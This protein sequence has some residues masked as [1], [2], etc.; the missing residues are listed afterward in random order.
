MHVV[1]AFQVVVLLQGD[2][3]E[4]E[5]AAA[6][7]KDGGRVPS[8]STVESG[9]RCSSWSRIVTPLPSVTGTIERL[10]LPSRQAVSARCWER[11]A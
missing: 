9:R 6:S 4:A 3:V 5:R 11:T 8:D 7:A 10:N 2:G 1:D